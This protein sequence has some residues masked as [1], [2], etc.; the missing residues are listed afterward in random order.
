MWRITLKGVVAHRLRY[1]LTALAVLL[2]VAFIAGTL[3]LTDSI[4]NTFNG[5]FDQIYQGTAAVVRAKQ[6]FSPGANFTAQ[7]DRIDA[8]IASTVEKVPGVRAV[9]LG[10]GGYAQLIGSNGKPIGKSSNGPPTLGEAWTDVAALNPLHLLPG[11]HAPRNDHQVVIDKH[12]AQVGHLAVGDRVVV[13]TQLPPATYTI[14]GIATWGSADSPL[15]ASIT[16]FDPTTAAR[17]LGEPGKADQINVEADPGVSQAVL[18][19]RIRSAIRSDP[20][21]EVVTGQAVTVEGQDAV[22]QAL[23]FFNTFL[24]VFA[25]IALFVGSFII[26]NTFSITVAQRLRELGLLRA[27]GASRRQVTASVLGE[28]LVVGLAA[29]GAGLLVGIGLAIGLKAVLAAAGIALPATGLVISGRT[30]VVAIVVGTL[31]TALAAIGPARRAGRIPPVAAIHQV[32]A[33]GRAPSRR[34]VVRGVVITAIGLVVLAFTLV[35][36]SSN[37][38]LKVGIGAATTFVGILVLGPFVARSIARFL[39]A[40]FARRSMTS[41]LA[42]QNAMRNPSRTAATAAA[43]MVG[44]TLVSVIT[45]LASSTKASVTAIIDSAVRADFVVNNGAIAGSASGLSPA[46][47]QTLQSLPEV[48]ATTGIRS[49]VAQIYGKTTQVVATDL[50]K[51]D[52]LFDIGVIRGNLTTVSPSGV[53]VSSQLATNKHLT[54]GSPISVVFSTTGRKTYTVQAI[55]SARDLAGDYVFPLSTAEQSFS[56]NLDLDI[57]VKLAPGVSAGAGRKAIEGVL[58]S[59]PNANLLDQAQYKAQQEQ[60]INQLLN[61]VYALLGLAVIIALIGIA[62]TLALSTYERTRE[63]GL[64]RAVGMTRPQLRS[65]IRTESL[66][67]SFFGALEGLV[68]GVLF[69]WALVAA[70][71]PSGVNK[72]D[73]PVV[74]L[75]VLGAIA[76]LA[77]IAAAVAP[78]RRAARLDVLRAITTE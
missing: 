3:V 44:V 63:L 71:G 74:Q 11:G 24:L 72:I 49:G 69:G 41:K 7:R 14:T 52:R 76:G 45:I 78:G 8:S 36:R 42:Q 30:L 35:S 32:T 75:L 70:L 50:K 26:F 37:E 33:V 68:L 17:V 66:I 64:L 29:S 16:A 9:S 10:I 77:G 22:H 73:V 19:S 53:A 38:V 60:Q 23:S 34:R 58:A 51:V 55:Y 2:G 13:L 54:I 43:L 15:G 18:V 4:N 28:S 21:L 27:V 1:A 61:L 47:E 6:P 62:N 12:S 40:P 39:G 57:F 65:T 48:G 25:F 67:I 56:Q 5:L 31:I 59:Y 20:K 46:L